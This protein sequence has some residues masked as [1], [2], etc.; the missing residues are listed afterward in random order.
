MKREKNSTLL[1]CIIMSLFVVEVIGVWVRETGR[2]VVPGY[3]PGVT[4]ACLYAREKG[5]AKLE[6]MIFNLG[7]QDEFTCEAEEIVT[8][9]EPEKIEEALVD[10]IGEPQ[11]Q[12]TPEE[13]SD[14]EQAVLDPMTLESEFVEVDDSYF[15]DALFIGDSRV[16]GLETYCEI[17]GAEYAAQV[18]LTIYRTMDKKFLPV[19][20]E[21]TR[22]SIRELLG[23]KQYKKIYLMVGINELGTGN[24]QHFKEA[25]KAVIDEI[26][27]LQPQAVIFIQSVLHVTGNKSRSEKNINNENINIR[28]EGLSSL[29]D[30]KRIFYLDINSAYDDEEGNLQAKLSGDGVHLK[31]QC[32]EAWRAYLYAHGIVKG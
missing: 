24:E 29:A 17:P 27:T 21:K 11:T 28:N 15:E 20:G 23:E 4:Y 31:A 5:I 9:E 25:Y 10:E 26:I 7:K 2:I 6:E 32:Y 18:G 14:E 3:Q 16:V 22:K 1:L 30:N 8:L 19:E 12:E 13:I